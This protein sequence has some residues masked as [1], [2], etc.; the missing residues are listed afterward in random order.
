MSDREGWGFLSNGRKAHYFRG[1]RSLCRAW[2][3]W[4]ENA[5]SWCATQEEGGEAGPDDCVACFRKRAKEVA[6]S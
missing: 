4:G 6:K 2:L 5:V 1:C 3:A